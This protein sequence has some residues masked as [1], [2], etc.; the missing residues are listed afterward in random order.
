MKLNMKVVPVV[1]FLLVVAATSCAP[2]P[3]PTLDQAT[4]VARN[5]SVRLKN[6]STSR[7]LVTLNPGDRVDVLERQANWYRIRYGERTQ[8]WME[9]STVLTNATT[10][11]IKDMVIA[12]QDQRPQNTA[13][14]R[15]DTNF[16]IEPGR[17][18]AIIRRLD[19]GTM[20]EV[21]ERVTLERPNSTAS[22]DIWL[23]VRPSPT[24][25]GWVIASLV[26]FSVPADIAQYTEGYIYTAV[27]PLREVQDSLAGPVHWY[28]VAE[29]KPGGD[30]QI[31]FDG[32]RVFT[33]NMK[34][35]RY[36]TAFRTKGLR[37]IYPLE[38]GQQDGNPTFRVHE[39]GA[40]ARD[41]VMTGVIVRELK[42]IS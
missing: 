31:D 33:W 41:Y 21:L 19:A 6:S 14:M 12:S 36:E 1:V 38:A 10:A 27:K 4:V 20:V 8:G 7:T 3:E 39:L 15:E 22:F 5:A 28:L 17:S 25:V 18:T 11:R 35:H 23:K 32:I 13:V 16:R 40:D 24:E 26:D 37:G 9:E 29:R 34:K 30:P 42:K 2:E